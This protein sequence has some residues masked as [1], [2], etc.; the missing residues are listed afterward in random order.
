MSRCERK[1][2][3]FARQLRLLTRL[4]AAKLAVK[5]ELLRLFF[6]EFKVLMSPL[7]C[8]HKILLLAVECL[9][10]NPDDIEQLGGG[11]DVDLETSAAVSRSLKRRVSWLS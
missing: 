6:D 5:L 4:L 8:R 2:K 7:D 11:R 9:E 3:I 1:A 10:A